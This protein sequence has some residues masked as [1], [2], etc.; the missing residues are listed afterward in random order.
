MSSLSRS[1]SRSRSRSPHSPPRHAGR[2]KCEPPKYPPGTRVRTIPD[3]SKRYDD[4]YIPAEFCRVGAG[5]VDSIPEH[6]PLVL[7]QPI[8]FQV[9][10]VKHI[11]SCYLPLLCACPHCVG[12]LPLNRKPV[13][14]TQPLS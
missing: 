2:Y 12:T 1:K 11:A 7:T 10:K 8:D 9:K 5:W 13:V 3:V 14:L 6:K 4:M